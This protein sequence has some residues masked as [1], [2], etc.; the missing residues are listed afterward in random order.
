MKQWPECD[1]V[2]NLYWLRNLSKHIIQIYITCIFWVRTTMWEAIVYDLI[3]Y[4]PVTKNISNYLRGMQSSSH[5][6][7]FFMILTFASCAI[8]LYSKWSIVNYTTKQKAN[9]KKMEMRSYYWILHWI[10]VR[11]WDLLTYK[12]YS[13]YKLESSL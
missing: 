3:N 5:W 1:K 11:R 8:F 12:K 9:S 6:P 10:L 7:C 4:T 13:L 2:S